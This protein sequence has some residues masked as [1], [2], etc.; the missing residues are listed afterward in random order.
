MNNY[1]KETQKIYKLLQE[2]KP[3]LIGGT[4]FTL[5]DLKIA[6]NGKDGLGGLIEE[7]FGVWAEKNGFNI[8]NPKL[9]KK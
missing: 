1:H 4:Q 6:I 9:Q 8:E 2:I 7:W 3:K 5:A